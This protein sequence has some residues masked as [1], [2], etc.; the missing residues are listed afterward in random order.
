MKQ[1]YLKNGNKISGPF[2]L[3][4]L[5]YQ[6]INE[7]T[8]I[9]VDDGPW[10]MIVQNS[11]FNFLTQKL[12]SE[13][14][15]ASHIQLGKTDINQSPQT[16]KTVNSKIAFMVAIAAA[17]VLLAMGLAAFIFFQGNQ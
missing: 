7:H 5:K 15:S 10:Q 9:R 6:R 8:Q 11:D 12:D 4:D 2:L 1:Y 3:D 13:F 17:L 14:D 16:N